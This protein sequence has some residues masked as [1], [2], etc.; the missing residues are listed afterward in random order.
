MNAESTHHMFEYRTLH[1]TLQNA[2]DFGH[3]LPLTLTDGIGH[4]PN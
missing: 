1:E 2:V 4:A 3:A